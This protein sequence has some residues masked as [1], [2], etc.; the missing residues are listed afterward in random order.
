MHPLV[1]HL[2][3]RRSIAEAIRGGKLPQTLLV[4]GPGG[5]G[6][7]RF[8]LW[9]AQ[10]IL[11]SGTAGEVEPCGAC[12]ECRLVLGLAH[13]DVHWMIP[14]PRPKAVADKQVEEVEE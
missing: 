11:C 4:V 12:R 2:E 8:G 10:R 13:P 1:G 9:V 7:Q 6:K 14:V 5:V 3:A